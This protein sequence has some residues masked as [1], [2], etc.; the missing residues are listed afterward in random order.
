MEATR[1]IGSYLGDTPRE[2]VWSGPII[3]TDVHANVPSIE[4]LFDYQDQLWVQWAKER[5]FRGPRGMEVVYPPNAPT[6]AR[7]E[8]RVEKGLV[9]ASSLATVQQQILDPWGV[10]RAMIN[11]YYA[12]DSLRHPD[13]ALALA[14]AVNDWVI[15]QGPATGRLDRDPVP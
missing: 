2:Q 9:P 10:E 14:R 13:W 6:N 11:C 5:G 15:D 3:D 8:W 1:V 7:E 4:V 12:I